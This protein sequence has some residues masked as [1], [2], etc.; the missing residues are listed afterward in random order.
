MTTEMP[1]YEELFDSSVVDSQGKKVGKVEAVW[2]DDLS[3]EPEFVGVETNWLLKGKVHVIPL[4]NAEYDDEIIR[5]P[6]T[7]DQIKNAP[8]RGTDPEIS[9]SEET[10]IF[11]YFGLDPSISPSPTA[12][13]RGK[14][15][16]DLGA[17]GTELTTYGATD[18][19]VGDS[20][21]TA[22]SPRSAGETGGM[23]TTDTVASRPAAMDTADLGTEG[24]GTTDTG[25]TGTAATTDMGPAADLVGTED[26]TRLR[27]VVRGDE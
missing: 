9:R 15:T 12:R 10:L 20:A 25:L 21:P 24:I 17:P 11:E 18:K 6:Y 19:D 26:D 7:E 1:S 2:V 3:N 4:T 27:R 23:E 5:M 13:P 22:D 14:I 16:T 8:S